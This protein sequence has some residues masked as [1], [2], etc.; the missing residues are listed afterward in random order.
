MSN[1]KTQTAG[2]KAVDG[3]QLQ[4]FMQACR[5]H[6]EDEVGR[7]PWKLAPKG[8]YVK[9]RH[10][11][12]ERL[13]A[14]LGR[15]PRIRVAHRAA[16]PQGGHRANTNPRQQRKGTSFAVEKLHRDSFKSTSRPTAGCAPRPGRR[17]ST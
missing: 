13:L 2:Q 6:T 12:V 7:N 3:Y 1:V 9:A 17:R 5:R 15:A 14:L 10:G 11:P 16:L 4:N 8:R